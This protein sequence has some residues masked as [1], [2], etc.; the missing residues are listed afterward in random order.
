MFCVSYSFRGHAKKGA[1][2]FDFQRSQHG[3]KRFIERTKTLRVQK[4]VH[5]ICVPSDTVV[6]KGFKTLKCCNFHI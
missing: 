1:N 2:Q 5:Q 4:L 3:G 6:E